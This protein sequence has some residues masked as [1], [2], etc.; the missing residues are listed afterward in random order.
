MVNSNRKLLLL[1]L[2]T[3][4][5]FSG[6]ALLIATG[7][8]SGVGTGMAMSQDRRTSGM[9]IE[10]GGI[11]SRSGRRISEEFG[12]NAHVNVTSFNRNVLL[13]GEVPTE[14]VKREVERLVGNVEHVRNVTNETAVSDVSSFASR[15]N[16]TLITSKVK[17]RFMDGGQFQINHV[18]VVT[19]NGT[20]YL[21]GLVKR[22]EAESAVE[23]ARAT[24]GVKKVVKVFEY[25][26]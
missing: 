16:D 4:P 21:L 8:V 17:G 11:E 12:T 13:T 20:V 5:F 24:S 15:S 14:T 9:F 18:K 25:L 23:I 22:K 26:D 1:L 2:M 6:C 10:D 7:V 3:L 19:E